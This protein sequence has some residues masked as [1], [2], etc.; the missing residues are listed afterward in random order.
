MNTERSR[1]V[2][3]ECTKE[4]HALVL[5]DGPVCKRCTRLAQ[6]QRTIGPGERLPERVS[7][8]AGK[9]SK[10]LGRH[11]AM[12]HFKLPPQLRSKAEQPDSSCAELG[13][14]H[15]EVTNS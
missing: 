14:R 2:C 9:A 6:L 5:C 10:I 8:E 3:Y 15:P 13:F 7:L 12:G 4:V 11:Q 1:W